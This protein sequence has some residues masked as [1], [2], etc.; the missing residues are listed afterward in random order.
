MMCQYNTESILIKQLINSQQCLLSLNGRFIWSICMPSSLQRCVNIHENDH[1]EVQNCPN[2]SKHCQDGF[3]FAF[4]FL[5][6]FIFFIST[7]DYHLGGQFLYPP[8]QDNLGFRIKTSK[9]IVRVSK[10]I[11]LVEPIAEFFPIMH[12]IKNYF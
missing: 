12:Y 7:S 4:L 10:F 2:N 5:T 6:A 11:L 3:F 1:N 8:L 9:R